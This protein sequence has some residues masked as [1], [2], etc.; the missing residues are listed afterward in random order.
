MIIVAALRAG[1]L[2]D[3]RVVHI[4]RD[5]RAFVT[6][7]MNWKAAS[8]RRT[9]LHHVVPAW[10]PNPWLTGDYSLG[11]WMAMSKFEHF[12]WTWHYKNR[13]FGALGEL[14][15]YRR[16]RFEDLTAVGGDAIA[17]LSA[18]VGLDFGGPA[19]T[20][21]RVNASNGSF[22]D[23]Q[24]WTPEQAALLHSHCQSLMAEYGY[25]GERRWHELCRMVPRATSS[26]G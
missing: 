5:P 8:V 4:V 9:F 20:H 12:S 15:E 16:Y 6:S 23:W 10:Q 7:F 25:G 22:P 21:E 11:R 2:R 1:A 13:V 18:F 3:A 14:A 26:V 24:N 17:D 19:G